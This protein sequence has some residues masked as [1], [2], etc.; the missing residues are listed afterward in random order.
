M[1]FNGIEPTKYRV[2]IQTWL[3]AVRNVPEVHRQISMA[4]RADDR[5]TRLTEAFLEV[6]EMVVERPGPRPLSIWIDR[7]RHLFTPLQAPRM[8]DVR[9]TMRICHSRSRNPVSLNSWSVLE[10]RGYGEEHFL[11]FRIE[12]HIAN[13]E[14]ASFHLYSPDVSRIQLGAWK[15]SR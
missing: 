14:R 15:S 3:I 12:P 5:P 2:R 7:R 10:P 9:D 11:V 8:S 4:H 6:G 13:A 1:V